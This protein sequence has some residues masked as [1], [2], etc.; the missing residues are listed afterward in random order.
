MAA[1][2]AFLMFD[3]GNYGAVPKT[4]EDCVAYFQG[5][6]YETGYY[7]NGPPALFSFPYFP[8]MAV[9]DLNTGVLV[10]KDLSETDYLMPADILEMVQAA[11]AE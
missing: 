8:F 9:I 7:V 5:Y 11:N 6:G 10:G 4:A 2:G 1:N 3:S